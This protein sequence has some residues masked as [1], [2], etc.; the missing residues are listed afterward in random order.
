MSIRG[1][2]ILKQGELQS[3]LGGQDISTE[4]CAD[5]LDLAVS[6]AGAEM[7]AEMIQRTARTL[8]EVEGA[9][10]RMDLGEFG[11]CQDCDNEIEGKRLEITPWVERC[12]RCQEL[13]EAREREKCSSHTVYRLKNSRQRKEGW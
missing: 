6:A 10:G 9:L 7:A 3:L 1:S 8:R 2:L 13:R 11:S 5:Y 12:I 4:R